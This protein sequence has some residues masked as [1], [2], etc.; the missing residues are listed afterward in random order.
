MALLQAVPQHGPIHLLEQVG[1]DLHD[2][3]RPDAENVAAVGGV[4]D[5]AQTASQPLRSERVPSGHDPGQ[6][7][8]GRGE[9]QMASRV[10]SLVLQ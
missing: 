9:V 6:H 3:V 2:Q 1:L 10:N 5:L 8:R 4:M 7:A